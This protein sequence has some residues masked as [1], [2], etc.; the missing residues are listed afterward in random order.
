MKNGKTEG[1]VFKEQAQ[2]VLYK[3]SEEYANKLYEKCLILCNKASMS[4]RF[5][6]RIP[7]DGFEPFYDESHCEKISETNYKRSLVCD[8][9]T[10]LLSEEDIMLTAHTDEGETFYMLSFDKA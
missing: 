2:K 8:K 5:R 6:V 10:A 9:L 3:T 7:I 4:G 1:K